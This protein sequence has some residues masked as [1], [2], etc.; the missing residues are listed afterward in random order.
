VTG[1]TASTDFPI[2]PDAADASLGGFEDAFVTRLSESG[3]T[4]HYSTYFG[5]EEQDAGR[6][7]AL[8]P[9]GNAYITGVRVTDEFGD[10]FVVKIGKADCDDDG[11]RDEVDNCPLVANPDQRDTDGD[12]IGD[13]CDPEPG[14]TPR[15]R[16]DGSGLVLPDT[17]VRLDVR[18]GA[19]GKV[20]GK[21]VLRDRS[22][23]LV[24][25]KVRL[26]SLIVYGSQATIRGTARAGNDPVTMKV[27]VDDVGPDGGDQLEVV[28]SNGYATSGELRS[29]DIAVS[30]L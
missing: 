6:G 24:L 26:T 28:L 19:Q 30:C 16:V 2:T 8:D 27:D 12:G 1:M 11:L 17:Q 5:G 20:G 14:T 7:I 9:R 4:L 10:G 13:E 21:V 18:S 3:A 15:C 22:A 23:H 29:G 25:Q